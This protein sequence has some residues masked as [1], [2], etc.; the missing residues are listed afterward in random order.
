MLLVLLYSLG[1]HTHSL[2]IPLL[3]RVSKYSYMLTKEETF[4]PDSWVGGVLFQ[5]SFGHIFL[6]KVQEAYPSADPQAL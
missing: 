1:E 4:N 6:Q 2:L 5:I 3:I